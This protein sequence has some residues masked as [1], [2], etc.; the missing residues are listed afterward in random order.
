MKLLLV[1][2]AIAEDAESFAVTGGTDALRP[3]TEVGRRKMRKGTNRLRT[4]IDRIDVLAC[5]P[6]VR[7]RETAE[8]IARAYGDLP[9]LERPELDFIYPVEETALWL[10]QYRPEIVMAIV[11]HEPHLSL[12]SGLLL[13]AVPCPL[14][15]FRKGGV[16][17]L[18]FP[19]RATPG[20]GVLHWV[21]TPGQLR[22]L[23]QD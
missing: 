11:G 14:V 20:E 7:A 4:Q 19:G 10:G 6:R 16:A 5:S 2:H 9:L 8:I 3:L 21:L 13:T 22:G 1:R 12:L 18:E 17:L 15:I 23:K